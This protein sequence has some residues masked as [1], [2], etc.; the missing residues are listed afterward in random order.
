M[1][2]PGYTLHELSEQRNVE[3]RSVEPQTQ[4][5][6]ACEQVNEDDQITMSISYKAKRSSDVTWVS[7]R[8]PASLGK[9]SGVTWKEVRRHSGVGWNSGVGQN[10]DV[11]PASG[12]ALAALGRPVV[13][14]WSSGG[15]PAKFRWCSGGGRGGAVPS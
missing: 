7:S 10:S 13:L 1:S 14:R 5:Y 8:I 9:K 2:I 11:A 15:V 4:S 3:N 12:R 6:I